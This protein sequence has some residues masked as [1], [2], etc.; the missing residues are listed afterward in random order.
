MIIGVTGHRDVDQQPGELLMFARLCVS[1]MSE[2][3]C[4]EIIT[5][6]ARGWDLKIARASDDAGIPFTAAIPFPGQSSRWSHADRDDWEWSALRASKVH[7][8]SRLDL[9]HAF[10]RRNEWIVDNCDQLWSLYDGRDRGG[11]RNCLLYAERVGR[12]VVPLWEPWIR[13]RAERN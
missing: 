7:I 3:G 5:G 13:F 12:T 4:T 8:V 6:M 1:R 11:T 10:D 2:S 9:D